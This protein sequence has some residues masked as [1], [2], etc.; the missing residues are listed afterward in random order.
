M[1]CQG[2][3]ILFIKKLLSTFQILFYYF[4]SEHPTTVPR[5]S[6]TVN[7][8]DGTDDL[9]MTTVL[10]PA[11]RMFK[12]VDFVCAEVPVP[13]TLVRLHTRSEANCKYEWTIRNSEKIRR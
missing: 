3:E 8:P 6:S 5:P 7:R 13:E 11:T 12:V 10:Q 2:E 1:G 9:C 4:H